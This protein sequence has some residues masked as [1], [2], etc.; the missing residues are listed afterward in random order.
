M[1]ECED[2]SRS[3]GLGWCTP[4]TSGANSHLVRNLSVA[5]LYTDGPLNLL[6]ASVLILACAASGCVIA[7]VLSLLTLTVYIVVLLV[8]H[9][10]DFCK[11][12]VFCFAAVANI[13]GTAVV[14]FSGV[15]LGEIAQVGSYAGSLPLLVFSRWL[16]L[17]IVVGLGD[18]L[19]M[20]L[21]APLVR[22]ETYTWFSTIVK[23]IVAALAVLLADSL[24]SPPA[25]LLGV[26]R[27]V[28]ADLSK[29]SFP[30]EIIKKIALYLT[31][32]LVLSVKSGS[33]KWGV[34]GICLYVIYLLWTGNK[35]G[36]FLNLVSVFLIVFYKELGLFLRCHLKATMA[37]GVTLFMAALC[38]TAVLYGF[39]DSN[40]T[41]GQYLFSRT[42]QQGQL[43]W[44]TYASGERATGDEEFALELNGTLHGSS[45]I[46]EN[47]GSKYG[48]Y[49]VMYRVAPSEKVD[50]K[51]MTGSRY[52]EGGYAAALYY[53]GSTGVIIFSG[54]MAIGVA[55]IVQRLIWALRELKIVDVML[56]ARLF[57]VIQTSLSMFTFSDLIDPLSLASY[58]YLIVSWLMSKKR[59]KSERDRLLPRGSR[60]IAQK[61]VKTY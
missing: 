28:Y 26:D 7:D 9:P 19:E 60:L 32:P 53:G 52:T 30:I 21:R 37:L 16:F 5:R 29:S 18:K 39:T 57:F 43:W 23:L 59:Q 4:M 55:V 50:A 45:S 41:V 1:G 31:F 2:A 42:A 20:S 8:R 54:I 40:T 34:A 3:N 46:S 61:C 25:F 33:K 6:C 11:Y 58:G 47:V 38:M 48:I 17:A 51:L 36:S 10:E 49:G 27:F 13:V 12:F 15:T 22:E 24:L 56:L 35:F 44:A 14:E